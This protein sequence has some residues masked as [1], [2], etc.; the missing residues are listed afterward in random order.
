MFCLSMAPADKV[1]G[2]CNFAYILLMFYGYA[3]AV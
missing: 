1:R 3:C 2:H